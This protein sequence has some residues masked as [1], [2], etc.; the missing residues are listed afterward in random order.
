M[1][2]M[3]QGMHKTGY[4]VK[5]FKE[6]NT[7]AFPSRPV[8]PID[9]PCF[10]FVSL[11]SIDPIFE[12]LKNYRHN[13]FGLWTGEIDK[14]GY[15][16]IAAFEA[17][18]ILNQSLPAVLPLKKLRDGHLTS[19]SMEHS[20]NSETPLSRVF[21]LDI[22][23][24]GEIVTINLN[25]LDAVPLADLWPVPNI[26]VYRGAEFQERTLK[27]TRTLAGS[28]SAK[29]SG[30]AI[31]KQALDINDDTGDVF[32]ATDKAL[33]NLEERTKLSSIFKRIFNQR[34]AWKD[35]ATNDDRKKGKTAGSESKTS[36]L[37]DLAGWVRWHTPFADGLIKQ[38]H[39]RMNTVEKLINKGDID[40]ALKLALKLGNSQDKEKSKT[41]F[42]FRLPEMRSN[43]DF[44]FSGSR[45]SM[46]V[47]GGNTQHDMLQ[48]YTKLAAELE[49]KGDYKRAAYIRSQLLD[50]HAEAV[51]TLERGELFSEAAKLSYDS[52]QDPALTIRLYYKAGKEEQALALARRTGCF[53]K[54]AED[55]RTN[56]PEFHNLVIK[57]WTD[58]LLESH[59]PLRALEVTD[60]LVDTSNNRDLDANLLNLRRGW[61]EAALE[62]EA[63]LSSAGQLLPF[64][65]TIRALLTAKWDGSDFSLDRLQNFPNATI[66][67][68][69]IFYKAFEDIQN[70]VKGR[71]K[72]N[73]QFFLS[74]L[75]QRADKVQLEQAGFWGGPA[76]KFLDVLT[77]SFMS[78]SPEALSRDD[79]V[80]L[81]RLLQDAPLPVLSLDLKKVKNFH[82]GSHNPPSVVSL[83][84]ICNARSSQILKACV[85]F[86]GSMVVW[87]DTDRFEHRDR[88]GKILWSGNI[89]QVRDIIP[90][91]GSPS[92]LIL[93]DWDE[94]ETRLTLY[95]SHKCRF[96]DVGII[97][98][99][100]WHDVISD[101]EWLV[102][103]DNIVGSID[104]SKLFSSPAELE[105]LWSVNTT[106]ELQIIAFFQKGNFSSWMTRNVSKSRL[107]V[108]QVWHYKNARELE[109]YY[110]RS[111]FEEH[112]KDQID[113]YWGDNGHAKYG[114]MRSL[115]NGE[116]NRAFVTFS[117]PDGKLRQEVTAQ[118]RTRVENG[119]MGMD[120]F[121]VCDFQRPLVVI[122]PDKGLKIMSD[123]KHRAFNIKCSPEMGLRLLFRGFSLKPDY[124]PDDMLSNTILCT[125]KYG[126]LIR[127]NNQTGQ[128]NIF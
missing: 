4:I 93:R 22:W 40:S 110:C 124:S 87:Y 105:F 84:Q 35:G 115:H 123:N 23:W 109:E 82:K 128:V 99:V 58:M 103:I 72:D 56:D 66:G 85:L 20:E 41:R 37:E 12:S 5:R 92:V 21:A 81:Q 42:P 101:R 13:T 86:N 97:H 15:V 7:Q 51:L 112:N 11:T 3:G 26:S 73:A 63:R 25:T 18:I 90:I 8:L 94:H 17:P 46:P 54:L 45:V 30:K 127:I 114:F 118:A 24:K 75:F 120:T 65:L 60:S 79:I 19:F 14:L 102:Q 44:S 106:N 89:S 59:Q 38:M 104:I 34:S 74:A 55:S 10:G 27:I 125:D 76:R 100:A 96:R 33:E 117:V 32:S 98:L 67:Q 108:K 71:H 121:Q 62:M 6:Q 57:F 88:N 119:Y 50:D 2:V 113:W 95:E 83:P 53:D 69:A 80:K 48:R 126:R 47:L 107:G 91:G 49:S 36:L 39:E 77:R 70:I 111:H 16:T 78:H 31:V 64:D 29:P 52:Q 68:G 122:H 9:Q 61:L 116:D 1:L 43:L 28:P